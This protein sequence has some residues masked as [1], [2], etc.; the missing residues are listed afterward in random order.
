MQNVNFYLF[1]PPAGLLHDSVPTLPSKSS[2][3]L[4]LRAL[5]ASLVL[6]NIDLQKRRERVSLSLCRS[7][8]ADVGGGGRR[9]RSWFRRT[10]RREF[11]CGIGGEGGSLWWNGSGE[12]FY[13]A[14]TVI[15]SLSRGTGRE[16]TRGRVT[17]L[18]NPL[19]KTSPGCSG[20]RRRSIFIR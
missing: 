6:W 2:I 8:V 13:E 14:D 5:L 20:R 16:L 4:L 19:G 10:G 1:C 12:F 11:R 17:D 15:G 18:G 9:N 7:D 3:V